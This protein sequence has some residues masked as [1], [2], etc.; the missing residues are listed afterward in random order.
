LFLKKRYFGFIM[1]KIALFGFPPDHMA[2]RVLRGNPSCFFPITDQTLAQ[3]FSW[4]PEGVV[5]S[6]LGDCLWIIVEVWLAESVEQVS[7]RPDTIRAIVV[8]FTIDD[9][10]VTVTHLYG[11]SLGGICSGEGNYALLFEIKLRDDAEYINSAEYQEMVEE[12]LSQE[13]CR[14]TFI[15]R[16]EPVQPEILRIDSWD[17]PPYNLQ[18]CP[19]LNPTYPLLMFPE[20]ELTFNADGTFQS[21]PINNEEPTPSE[22]PN[23]IQGRII[24]S[25]EISPPETDS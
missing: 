24:S 3:G 22:G 15:R 11:S 25:P 17:E 12:G 6:T 2:F 16:E 10:G 4:K 9:K 18:S 20:G 1:N 23:I 13:Q 8:P 7:L 5:F 14:L 21:T 19:R